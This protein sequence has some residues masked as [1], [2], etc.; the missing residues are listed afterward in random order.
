MVSTNWLFGLLVDV[1]GPDAGGKG[2]LRTKYVVPIYEDDVVIACGRIA[3]V[4]DN[5]EGEMVYHVEIWC[6][7]DKGKK[8][9]VGEAI[10]HARKA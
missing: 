6:E 4:R 3:S 2:R 1:F 9:T 8:L 10:V 5:A 7:N